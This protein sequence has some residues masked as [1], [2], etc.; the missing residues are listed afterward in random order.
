M[1]SWVGPKH[2]R[3]APKTVVPTAYASSRTHRGS[4]FFVE[5]SICPAVNATHSRCYR[6]REPSHSI[7]AHLLRVGVEAL[8]KV[9]SDTDLPNANLENQIRGRPCKVRSRCNM[10]GSISVSALRSPAP[11]VGVHNW[12]D[13]R[14]K[15]MHPAGMNHFR[16][17]EITAEMCDLLNE[18]IEWLKSPTGFLT[19][20]SGEEVDGYKHRNDRLCQLGAE[21][22]ELN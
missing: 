19:D 17:R 14:R 5:R 20:V 16:I 9:L 1:R 15:K 4:G 22:S 12:T 13:F 11:S 18:Q 6:L 8:S 2:W 7:L 21:L 3:L 10:S